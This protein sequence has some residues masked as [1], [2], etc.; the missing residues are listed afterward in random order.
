MPDGVFD[1][2]GDGPARFVSIPPPCDEELTTIIEQIVR[3][4]AK[5]LVRNDEA[6]SEA[7]ALAALQAAELERRL[8][9]P[10]PF[11]HS[12]HSAFLEG[13]SLHAGVRIHEH[14]REGLERLCRL[15]GRPHNRDYAQLRIMRTSG[16]RSRG[17]R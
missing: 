17:G 13:F 14:D 1:S 8:R 5:V 3:R 7:D 9:F 11:K 12:R 10:D 2:A 16:S 15:C 4:T 6:E